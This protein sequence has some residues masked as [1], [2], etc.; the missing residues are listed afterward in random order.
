MLLNVF[1][2]ED[3]FHVIDYIAETLTIE[4]VVNLGLMISGAISYKMKRSLD[5]TGVADDK[6]VADNNVVGHGKF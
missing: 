1:F 2:D 4:Y 3:D 5:V 6:G